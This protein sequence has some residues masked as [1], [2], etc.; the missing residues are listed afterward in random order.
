MLSASAIAVTVCSRPVIAAKLTKTTGCLFRPMRYEAVCFARCVFPMPPCPVKISRRQ[1]GLWISRVISAS[2]VS[3]PISGP[4]DEGMWDISSV[5]GWIETAISPSESAAFSLRATF[6]NKS[7][8]SAGIC[9]CCANSS[10]TWRDGRRSSASIFKI[11]DTEQPTR[12]ASSCCVRSR[13]LRWRLTQFPKEY[14]K[15]QIRNS[16]ARKR[17]LIVL[18]LST[19]LCSLPTPSFL[20]KD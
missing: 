7:V 11:A 10:A 3:R 20:G 18:L 4:N 15:L 6:K 13:A 17:C 16:N 9:R 8:W 19:F 14:S 5:E 12:W 1:W 2:S